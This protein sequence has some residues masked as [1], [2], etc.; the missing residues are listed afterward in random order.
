MTASQRIIQLARRLAKGS[1]EILLLSTPSVFYYAIRNKL[2]NGIR[3]I[4]DKT[5]VT[6]FLCNMAGNGTK[7]DFMTDVVSER[8]YA[9]V[10]VI[11]PP[12][13]EEFLFSFMWLA[14]TSCRIG[15]HVILSFPPEGTRPGIRSEWLRFKNWADQLGMS[16]IIHEEGQLTYDA[17]FF[18]VNALSAEGINITRDWRKGDICVFKKLYDVNLPRPQIKNSSTWDEVQMGPVRL[19]I[20][21][22]ASTE[23]HEIDPRLSPI[24]PGEIL[25]SVSR[26]DPRREIANVWTSGNRIFS[27]S[28]PDILAHVILAHRNGEPA[29][30][31]IEFLINRGLSPQERVAVEESELQVKNIKEKEARE[32]SL[33]VHGQNAI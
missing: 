15:G 26:R 28:C 29:A 22:P 11:D 24:V 12:W 23:K 21:E 2:T 5:V 31:E 16:Q 4:G 30:K 27:C 14:A 13:Y 33:L 18:E 3:Y 17:P 6:E 19:K 9:G 20:R 7:C 32:L 10:V 25:P 8:S 1:D